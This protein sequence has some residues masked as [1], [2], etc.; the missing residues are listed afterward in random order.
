MNLLIS[1]PS[2]TSVKMLPLL[3]WLAGL[4]EVAGLVVFAGFN[5]LGDVLYL[6]V[7]VNLA[8]LFD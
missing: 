6:V 5:D 3:T 7:L 2:P 8:D 4:I 1:C